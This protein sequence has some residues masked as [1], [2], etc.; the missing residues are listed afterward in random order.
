MYHD[1]AFPDDLFAVLEGGYRIREYD[2]FSILGTAIPCSFG[3]P[4]EIT[5][6]LYDS[7]VLRDFVPLCNGENGILLIFGRLR[8]TFEQIWR[9]YY[10]PRQYRMMATNQQCASVFLSFDQKKQYPLLCNVK[11]LEEVCI[12]IREDIP[13]AINY[14]SYHNIKR[15]FGFYQRPMFCYCDR[16]YTHAVEIINEMTCGTDRQFA[17]LQYGD[18]QNL[19]GLSVLLVELTENRYFFLPML[20]VSKEVLERD[21]N[22]HRV[23]LSNPMTLSDDIIQS[24]DALTNCLLYL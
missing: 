12:R 8:D 7:T 23:R 20:N 4:Y 6:R 5:D 14:K 2:S 11:H 19:S 21:I 18:A 16:A 15:V 1:T 13:V 3:K 22:E 17:I 10:V 24:V 9:R